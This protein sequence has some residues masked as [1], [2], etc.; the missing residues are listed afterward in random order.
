MP[1]CHTWSKREESLSYYGTAQ[2][3]QKGSRNVNTYKL[4]F[5]AFHSLQVCDPRRTN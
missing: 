3:L 1:K 2:T 5:P 4:H